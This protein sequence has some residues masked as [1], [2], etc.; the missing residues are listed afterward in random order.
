[1]LNIFQTELQSYEW[2]VYSTILGQIFL[3]LQTV[4]FLLS[5]FKAKQMT[6]L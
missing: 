5:N 2:D 3:I 1:M 4:I 6:F